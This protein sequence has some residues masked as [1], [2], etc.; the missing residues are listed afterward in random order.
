MISFD[1]ITKGFSIFKKVFDWIKPNVKTMETPTFNVN[2]QVNLPINNGDNKM[3]ASAILMFL[4]QY[5]KEIS[6]AIVVAALS[7]TITVMYFIIESKN[8]TITTLQADKQTAI[9]E[10]NKCVKDNEGN[11]KAIDDCKKSNDKCFADLNAANQ[12]CDDKVKLATENLKR[13]GDISLKACNAKL[14]VALGKKCPAC[15]VC[16]KGDTKCPAVE[17]CDE[18][19]KQLNEIYKNK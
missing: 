17:N 9:D 18:L 1:M 7:I 2:P 13:D 10:K 4:M 16:E 5:W 15:P 12:T 8:S 6:V 3:A 11:N 14:Q 19:R